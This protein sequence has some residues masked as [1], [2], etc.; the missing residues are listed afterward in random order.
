MELDIGGRDRGVHPDGHVHEAERDGAGPIARGNAVRVPGSAPPQTWSQTSA[1]SG[2][3]SRSQARFARLAH[4][5][6]V[7]VGSLGG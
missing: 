1:R 3:A 7:S 5:G 4:S 2:P 6:E